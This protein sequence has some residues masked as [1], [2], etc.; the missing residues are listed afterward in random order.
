MR[1]GEQEEEGDLSRCGET[2]RT[3]RVMCGGGFGERKTEKRWR[4]GEGE[5]REG[6]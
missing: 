2:E 1:I 4:D 6:M 5:E 3:E